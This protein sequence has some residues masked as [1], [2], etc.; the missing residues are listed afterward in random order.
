MFG[1]DLISYF[2]QNG[3]H[4][5]IHFMQSAEP[6]M[7]KVQAF[8]EA[9]LQYPDQV[10]SWGVHSNPV[11]YSVVDPV[12]RCDLNHVGPEVMSFDDDLGYLTLPGNESAVWEAK[13][14]L[15]GKIKFI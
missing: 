6:N 14:N 5:E 11:D 2:S 12:E 10:W 13:Y 15:T 9:T 7:V 4:G 3:L 1:I 8:L